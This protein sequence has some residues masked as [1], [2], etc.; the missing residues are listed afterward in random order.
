LYLLEQGYIEA[1][2]TPL[3]IHIEGMPIVSGNS[4]EVMPMMMSPVVTNS[5]LVPHTPTQKRTQ[6][7]RHY[8]S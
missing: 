6:A 1:A 8:V 5:G 2:C 4:G 3:T 7:A